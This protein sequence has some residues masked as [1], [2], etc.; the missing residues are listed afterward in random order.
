[1]KN[2]VF[3]YQKSSKKISSLLLGK[4]SLFKTILLLL[5]FI[6]L[7]PISSSAQECSLA[8][9]A[10]NNIESVNEEGRIYFITLQNNSSEAILLNLSVAN[11]NS[12]N[13][14]DETSS[15]DNVKVNARIMNAEGQEMSSKIKLEPKQLLEFQVKVTVPEGTPIKRWNNLLLKASSDKCHNYSTSLILYTFIPNPEEK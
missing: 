12:G 13:N 3:N 10:K 5:F 14:P 4:K 2:T 8:L 15:F 11:A 9:T 1:M 6:L 7:S